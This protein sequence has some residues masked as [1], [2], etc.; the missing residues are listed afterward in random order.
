MFSC[1]TDEFLKISRKA[2]LTCVSSKAKLKGKSFNNLRIQL[3]K[4][5]KLNFINTALDTIYILESYDIENG[6]FASKIWNRVND[7]NY[8]YS[9]NKFNFDQKMLFTDYTVKLI[10]NWDTTDIR[11]E[12]ALNAHLIP[13][14][15][16]TGIKIV[17]SKK[18][19]VIECIKFKE[20][21]KIE[22]DR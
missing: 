17:F 13:E 19:S 11:K 7:L 5:G 14:K 4:C 8:T 21:F 16:L 20:F 18:H 10:Q 9:K 6:I 22:R 15:Y 2:E 3:Y 1:A 12:E